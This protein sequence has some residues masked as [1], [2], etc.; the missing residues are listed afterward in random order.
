VSQL[1]GSWCDVGIDMSRVE[2]LLAYFWGS[3]NDL[4]LSSNSSGSI[5]IFTLLTLLIGF[6]ILRWYICRDNQD[7]AIY[8]LELLSRIV[9]GDSCVGD[10]ERKA[11]RETTLGSTGG[12]GPQ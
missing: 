8:G 10:L 9:R 11:V 1:R 12:G 3:S 4:L 6:P 7:L 5:G 2:R